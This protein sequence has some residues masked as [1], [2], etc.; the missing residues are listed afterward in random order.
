MYIIILINDYEHHISPIF[1]LYRYNS[2]FWIQNAG[3]VIDSIHR[4]INM[5]QY[6]GSMPTRQPVP[7]IRVSID[8]Y[9]F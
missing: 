6:K 8:F 5:C 3:S 4:K 7:D 2:I 1:E 9:K